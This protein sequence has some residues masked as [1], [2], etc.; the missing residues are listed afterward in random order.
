MDTLTQLKYKLSLANFY[1]NLQDGTLSVSKVTRDLTA[2]EVKKHIPAPIKKL[3][4][5]SEQK[6]RFTYVE[7][8]L[9]EG[10]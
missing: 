5:I 6:A 4:T 8:T 7:I 2:R 3:V 1:V 10:E 9:K